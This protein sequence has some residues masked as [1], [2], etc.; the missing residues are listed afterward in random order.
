MGR[1]SGARCG[2][3]G[4]GRQGM[5]FGG[6]G[7][8]LGAAGTCICPKCGLLT[9]HRRGVPCLDERC[10]TCGVAL[11]RE[12]SAHHMEIERRRAGGDSDG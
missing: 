12:G 8:G 10:P 1:G 2:P 9:P 7:E 3:G 4:Q 5:G 6:G 11:V